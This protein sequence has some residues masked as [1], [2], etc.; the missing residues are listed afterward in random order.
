MDALPAVRTKI[1]IKA[2]GTRDTRDTRGP[3]AQGAPK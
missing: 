1:K 2:R 3:W